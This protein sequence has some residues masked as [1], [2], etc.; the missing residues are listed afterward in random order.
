VRAF[1]FGLT[2]ALAACSRRDPPGASREAGARLVG[3]PSAS[4]SSGGR[5]GRAPERTGTVADDLP[6]T[7]TGTRVASIAWRTWIYTDTG[8]QRGRYGYLRAGS[9]VDAREPAIVNEG[10]RGGWHRINPRGFVCIGMGASRDLSHPVVVASS[11][12]PKRGAGLPYIYAVA[13]DVAPLLYFRLPNAAEMRE[14]E[15]PTLPG[16]VAAYRAELARDKLLDLLGSP[17]SPPEFLA[18]GRALEKPYGTAQA[19]RYSAHM[20]RAAPKSG[21]AFASAF[22]WEG[23]LFGLTT[24]LDVVGLERTRLVRPSAL[25][26]IHFDASQALPVAFVTTPFSMRYSRNA[27][28]EFKPNGSFGYREALR[29]TGKGLPGSMVEVEGG[30]W[31]VATTLRRIEPRTSFPSLVT[32]DR[33]WIDVSIN[34]QTLVAYEGKRPV[35]ATLVTTGIGGLGDP[36]TTQATVR[37]SF[38]IHQKEVSSTMDGEGDGAADSYALRDVPFVQYFHEGYALHGTYWHDE[39]GS[40][41]S[42]GCINL[43]PEDAAWLFEWTDPSVPADWHGVVNKDRGTV[44]HIHP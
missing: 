42:H 1:V 27:A 23:R 44:V 35:F 10:C 4:A 14:S 38:M 19:P 24:E 25:R 3:S 5:S 6:F 34:Q 33:K 36:K 39:F 12:R 9:V 37:G 16:R 8:P 20:G 26:G 15:G 11:V 21:F 7:P 28:G 40:W 30:A 22:E 43:S 41:R 18:G 2:L 17:G 13:G 29:L 32:G 31:A